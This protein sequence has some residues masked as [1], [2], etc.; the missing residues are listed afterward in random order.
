MTET[1]TTHTPGPWKV[2]RYSD[3]QNAPQWTVGTEGGTRIADN[4]ERG[5]PQ[6]EA[7]ANAS[8][9]ASA[10][11][12]LGALRRLLD[13]PCCNEDDQEDETC[14]AIEKAIDALTKAEGR[15]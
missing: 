8:L 5:L 1:K 11:D 9:I 7:Q 14:E 13:C 3:S 12:L 10:P 2:Y 4:L 15:S 6:D